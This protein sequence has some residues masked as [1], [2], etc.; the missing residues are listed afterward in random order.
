M[1]CREP[2]TAPPDYE[3]LR[4]K[5][6]LSESFN[7]DYIRTEKGKLKMRLKA[8]H[9]TE[10]YIQLEGNETLTE[11]DKGI[12]IEFF[13]STGKRESKLTAERAQLYD[14]RG[15]AEAAGNVVV[16]NEK[17]ERLETERLRWNRNENKLTTGAFVKIYRPDEVLFGDSLEANQN[18][19]VYRIFKIKGTVTLKD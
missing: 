6:P 2:E 5:E 13:D 8:A 3:A 12:E 11:M 19:S 1:G 7:V 15:Y 14:K 9:L 17:N 4:R 16:I 18:F 10:K